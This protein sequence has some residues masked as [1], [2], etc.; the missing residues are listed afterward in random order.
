MDQEKFVRLLEGSR[1]LPVLRAAQADTVVT[2]GQKL[3]GIG[4]PML[5]VSWTTPGAGEAVRRLRDAHP[6][7]GAGTIVTAELATAAV[8]AGAMFLVAPNFSLDVMEVAASH[9]VP[10][11]PGAYTPQEVS[12]VMGHGIT[13]VKLFPAA[14]GGIGHLRALEEVF[15]TVRFVPTGGV[16][17]ADVPVW[18]DAGA[19]AVGV[20]GALARLGD[21]QLSE[22]WRA[23]SAVGQRRPHD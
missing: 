20:G 2:L 19:L 17:L 1:L 12:M 4:V 21:E 15:P 7:V 13:L 22:Q 18:I 10:Y 23:L 9:A 16:S 11:L 8:S 6:V 5:E 14:T 3:H